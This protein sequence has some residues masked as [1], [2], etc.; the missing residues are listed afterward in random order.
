MRSIVC[1]KRLLVHAIIQTE[2]CLLGHDGTNITY[3]AL[4]DHR[5]RI[6]LGA[7][8]DAPEDIL[9]E[10]EYLGIWREAPSQ[11]IGQRGDAGSDVA[12]Q[13]RVGMKYLLHTRGDVA[14]MNDL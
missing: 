13:F 11:A 6:G 7:F 10:S 2:E 9:S 8:V 14:D 12:D 3:E 1:R 5:K 4:R